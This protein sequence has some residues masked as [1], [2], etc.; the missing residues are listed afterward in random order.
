MYFLNTEMHMV[1]FSIT[2]FE[3]VMLC[4]QV[5]Y[6]LQRTSDRKRLLYLILLVLLILYN[7][8]SGFLPDQNIPVPI[9]IQNV[10][11]YLVAFSMSMYF[12]FYFYKAFDLKH[13]RFF[14]T[15]GSIFFLF[16]PFLLL[17]VV[18]Y[19]ITGDLDLSRQLT[20]IIPFFYGLVFTAATTRAF[21]IKF[22]EKEYTERTK[23]EMVIAAYL[24]LICWIILP[25]IVFFGDFQALEHS[26]TNAGFLV[27]TVVYVR[28][29]LFE[30]KK[31]YA[32]LLHTEQNRQNVIE[33]NCKNCHLTAREIEIVRLLA[34][35]LPYKI[36]G[37]TLSISEKTVA[38]HV[39]NIFAKAGVTNKVELIYKM[40]SRDSVSL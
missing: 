32:K 21:I 38:K 15:Y 6:F 35:G 3:L 36:I 2:V 28:T 17:F 33:D 25:V 14:A 29:S 8:C 37:A 39:S 10:V 23:Y 5:F 26:V 9:T 27:M 30:S 4:L 16:L 31:E 24:A 18:P 13:L 19:Y 12:V 20:V 40:E 11:A 1:T 22:R 34:K 7:V